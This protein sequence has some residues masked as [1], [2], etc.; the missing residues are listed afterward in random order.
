M[1]MVSVAIIYIAN[2]FYQEWRKND[3]KNNENRSSSSGRRDCT[4]SDP[5]NGR[6]WHCCP[7]RP[8]DFVCIFFSF[9]IFLFIH[10]EW[11][12]T[13]TKTEAVVPEAGIVP[14]AKCATGAPGI[15]KPSASTNIQFN[16]HCLTFLLSFTKNGEKQQRKPRSSYRKPGLSQ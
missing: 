8:H 9:F 13:T 15:A 4:C 10:K 16:F 3:P 12:K 5:R 6:P 11:G 2:L 1:G 7:K 14:A